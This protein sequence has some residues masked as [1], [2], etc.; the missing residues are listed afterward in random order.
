MENCYGMV[1]WHKWVFYVDAQ[2]DLCDL[3]GGFKDTRPTQL[4]WTT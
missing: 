3:L 4:L 1:L 2:N